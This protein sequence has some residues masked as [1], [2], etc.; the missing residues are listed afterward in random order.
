[1]LILDVL[2]PH[3]TVTPLLCMLMLRFMLV[4]DLTFV[5]SCLLF[6]LLGLSSEDDLADSKRIV[7]L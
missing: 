3:P 2:V 7:E 4:M 1:M 5:C 6:L